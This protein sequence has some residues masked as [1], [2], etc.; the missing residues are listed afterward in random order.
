MSIMGQNRLLTPM[1]NA[2]TSKMAIPQWTRNLEK[3][4]QTA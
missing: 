2:A 3:A 1:Q 4:C